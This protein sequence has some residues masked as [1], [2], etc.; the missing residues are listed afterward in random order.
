MSKPLQ[1]NIDYSGTWYRI[2]TNPN[3][4]MIPQNQ[5]LVIEKD[6]VKS[7]SFDELD[8][9]FCG[10]IQ[11]FFSISDSST[12]KITKISDNLF[13]VTFENVLNH[14]GENV[15]FSFQYAK[16]KETEFLNDMTQMFIKENIFEI[17]FNGI[18]NI[19]KFDNGYSLEEIPYLKSDVVLGD[20][21][22][23]ETFMGTYFL[24]FYIEEQISSMLPISHVSEMGF[25]V[26]GFSSNNKETFARKISH[27]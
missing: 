26:Y 25:Y 11:E 2:N 1:S 13:E 5:I 17:N 14:L 23:L 6:E 24:S 18:T 16:L 3:Q 22:K 8:E 12:S 7:F 15:S 21:L 10:T 4:V 9:V 27:R 19:L 20:Y